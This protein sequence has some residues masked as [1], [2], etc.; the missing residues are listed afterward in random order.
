MRDL[1]DGFADWIAGD[2]MDELPRDVALHASGCDGCLRHAAAFDAL[3]A[4]DPGAA[5]T[6]PL[7]AA[8]IPRSA[9]GPMRIARAAAGT[10]AVVIVL[11]AGAVVGGNLFRPRPTEPLV[12]ASEPTP[13]EGILGG[14]P[15]STPSP[16]PVPSDSATADASPS[17]SLDADPTFAVAAATPRPTMGG[18]PPP[19][20]TAPPAAPPPPAATP[21]PIPAPIVAPS[22]SDSPAPTPTPTPSPTNPPITPSPSPTPAPTAV[23]I[24]SDSPAPTPTPIPP[25]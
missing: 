14:V 12:S 17:P 23:P 6:P 13:A 18:G 9:T 4:V 22:P 11:G 21:E 16:T 3:L 1:H 8:P 19:V 7:R 15:A 25:P 20:S 5:P 10:M 24:P 2:G